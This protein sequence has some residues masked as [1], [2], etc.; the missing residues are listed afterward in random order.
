MSTARHLLSILHSTRPSKIL[1]LYLLVL[2]AALLSDTPIDRTALV[3]A[4]LVIFVVTSLGMQLNVLTDR[5][6]DREAKPELAA[7]LTASPRVLFWVLVCESTLALL[8]LLAIGASGRWVSFVALLIGGALFNLYSYNVLAPRRRA[9]L[10]LKAFWWGHALVGI[11]GYLALWMAGFSCAAPFPPD[12]R[13][14]AVACA[15]SVLD[16]G[17]FLVECAQDAADERAFGLKT[18]PALVG[19]SWTIAVATALVCVG[20]IGVARGSRGV[21]GVVGWALLWLVTVQAL[22]ALAALGTTRGA[23]HKSRRWEK[24][25]DATFLAARM[26]FVVILLF[27]RHS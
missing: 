15:A 7:R 4:E 16:Y 10:R 26:G 9:E 2:G 17:T 25:V 22:A 13:W 21:H 24:V 19:R 11:G 1:P 8:L 6:L 23:H 27:H 12:R 3:M 14:L 5:E 20:A 18:L